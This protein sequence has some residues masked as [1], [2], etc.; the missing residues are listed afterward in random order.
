MRLSVGCLSSIV[1]AL[2]VVNKT[3]VLE[4]SSLTQ[5]EDVTSAS[6]TRS[7]VLP[8]VTLSGSKPRLVSDN[9]ERFETAKELGSGGAG[10]VLLARDNDIDRPVA[11]KRIIAANET[12]A[13]V[14]R[15]VEEIRTLGALD[16][17]NIVPVH[18]VGIDASGRYFYVMKYVEGETLEHVIERLAAGDAEY[19][20]R[21]TYARRV[22][23]FR[24]ILRGI[25]F[26]HKHGVIHRDIKPA[27]VMIGRYGEVVVMDWGIARRI[28]EN[29]LPKFP[30]EVTT[31]TLS[32]APPRVPASMR[33]QTGALLG[34][35][36]YMSPEQARGEIDSLDERSDIYSL[37]VLFHEFLTLKHYLS[38]KTTVTACIA[39]VLREG[40]PFAH[41]VSNP[42]Q[43]APP[44]D[45]S[46]FVRHGVSKK[47][48]DR[49]GSVSEMLERLDRIEAGECPV[50]CPSTFAK[51]L[52]NVASHA[53]D[54]YPITT[55]G[56]AVL[57]F[58][59]FVAGIVSLVSH[60]V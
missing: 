27:N 54:H 40:V 39:G 46:H 25:Q 38:D 42:H 30:A 14:A 51:R 33:T 56:A 9:R 15:F 37:C 16:H 11:I 47:P 35:P 26:A 21:Y 3:T 31:R 50:E 60:R 5:S 4:T 13:T 52:T 43:S 24:Q 55:M 58:A 7:T 36:A 17:P 8:R 44:P 23:V 6:G 32:S 45:L 1:T 18:D 29:D 49:Y 20:R 10:E 19:H 53:V 22:E 2:R 28:R 57:G 48:H 41:F 59:T 12:P 34:T